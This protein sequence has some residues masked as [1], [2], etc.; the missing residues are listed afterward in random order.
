MSKKYPVDYR[1]NFSPN[2]TVI[3]IEITCCKRP[4]GE[5]RYSDEQSIA[6]PVCGKKHLL[7]LQYN[8]FHISQ[9]E[10]D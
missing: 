10:K 1:I 2:G 4:I 8:H 7:R 3:S 5:L 9:Q 6:C